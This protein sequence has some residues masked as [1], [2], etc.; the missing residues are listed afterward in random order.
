MILKRRLVLALEK[1]GIDPTEV[2]YRKNY[3]STSDENNLEKK[4]NN[5]VG[6]V[7]Q[8]VNNAGKDR[9]TTN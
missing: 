2:K 4:Q 5:M 7:N 8:Q 1:F 6:K 9:K 3:S